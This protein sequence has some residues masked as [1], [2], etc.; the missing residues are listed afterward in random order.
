MKTSKASVNSFFE[1][2]KLAIAGVSRDPKK[3]G[4]AVMNK[5][6]ETGFTIFLVHPEVD[7]LYGEPCY[8]NVSLLPENIDG[9]L[10]LTPKTETLGVVEETIKKGIP[11]I[12]IQQMSETRESVQ[13]A[14]NNKV[15]LIAG[16]CILMFAQPVEGFHKF[17]RRLKGFFG[18]L[19]R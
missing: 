12:W 15:N 3:F 19:P 16:Q 13:Y 14:Q 4:Y 6:K 5:L 10:I 9:M 7:I 11:N 18:L 17:H 2:R 1:S 8:R